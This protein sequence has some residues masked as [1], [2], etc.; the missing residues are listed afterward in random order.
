MG[1]LD[2]GQ[3][4]DAGPDHHTDTVSISLAYLNTAVTKGLR[5]CGDTVM[6]EGIEVPRFLGRHVGGDI[7]AFH[8]AR[9][10]R[11]EARRIEARNGPDT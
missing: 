10:A 8:L 9:D 6:N 3:S 1:I 4:A 7:E 5:T 2:Q 11:G